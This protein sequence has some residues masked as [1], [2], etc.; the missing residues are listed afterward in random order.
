MPSRRMARVD[1]P[2]VSAHAHGRRAWTVTAALPRERDARSSGGGSYAGS[3]CANTTRPATAPAH[4]TR[5]PD[6]KPAWI[7]AATTVEHA[8]APRRAEAHWRWQGAELVTEGASGERP[9]ASGAGLRQPPMNIG[10]P[11]ISRMMDVGRMPTYAHQ[12][13]RSGLAR[14]PVVI[15][16]R[17]VKLQ[18]D[19]GWSTVAIP[20]VREGRAQARVNRD[21]GDACASPQDGRHGVHYC[22]GAAD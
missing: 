6:G 11:G 14:P 3:Y 16:H 22:P 15:G 7:P 4:A 20:I 5:A 2:P 17:P 21:M 19:T 18:T 8:S 13:P 9:P 1:E 10:N 12:P